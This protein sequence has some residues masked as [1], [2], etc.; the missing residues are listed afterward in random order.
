MPCPSPD[1]RHFKLRKPVLKRTVASNDA[2]V[3]RTTIADAIAT[4]RNNA[5]TQEALA[6]VGKL[7]GIGP[8]AASLL[9]AVHDPNRVI[10]FSEEAFWWLCCDGE[11]RTIRQPTKE[12]L[13]LN[14]KAREVAERLDVTAMDVEKVAY[15]LMSPGMLPMVGPLDAEE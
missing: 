5:N 2:E 13:E 14:R 10:Y 7:K 4:Y 6:A 8:A 15:V 11:R 3:T 12:Y 1:R 9:L